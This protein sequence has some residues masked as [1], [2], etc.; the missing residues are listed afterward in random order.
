MAF[1]LVFNDK[2]PFAVNNAN[3]SSVRH[4]KRAVSSMRGAHE[5]A[6]RFSALFYLTNSRLVSEVE[7]PARARAT[8]VLLR[9]VDQQSVM[10]AGAPQPVPSSPLPLF[11]TH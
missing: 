10:C 7:K 8:A 1:E 2:G 4:P 11:P 3:C 9:G 6:L 5:P